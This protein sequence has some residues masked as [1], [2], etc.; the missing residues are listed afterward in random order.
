MPSLP[1]PSSNR[2]D[3]SLEDFIADI[4]T[5]PDSEAIAS[6]LG[7]LQ[8]IYGDE[9]IRPWRPSQ[10]ANGDK[11]HEPET[12]R[13]EVTLN[14]P[15]PHEDDTLRIL[16]SLPSKYPSESPP[17]LQLLS[18]YIGPFGVDAELFGSILRT[19]ISVNGVDW[20][21]DT[22]CVF[23]GLEN[24]VE[25]CVRWY[26]D[27]LSTQTANELLREDAKEHAVG[28]AE[29]AEVVPPKNDNR[30]VEEPV[31][32]PEGVVIYE[33]EPIV[34]RKS[35]FAGRACRITHPSQVPIILSY[36][37]SDRRIAKA[38]HPVIN[39]WRCTIGN[40]VHQDNDDDTE[41]AAGGRLAHLLQILDVDNVLV[42][43]TRYWGGTLLGPDR[44][45][46]IN[47]AA[48]DALEIGG[49]L[50]APQA[51]RHEGRAK[52]SKR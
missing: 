43:V 30:V 23:D 49:F 10:E 46:H 27:R 50:N 6:E 4:A 41:T 19:F 48:R 35:V 5:R 25:R 31:S 13:Y 40:T 44:F 39:A 2:A 29:P 7:V 8:S 9:A 16:V 26:E 38:A 15:S 34:D 17:Q 28:E 33:A 18:R 45:K 42:I 47:Q 11:F 24:V 36:L 22:V 37:L 21:P 20:I 14:L 12:I 3:I 51:K 1:D 32:L 52:G